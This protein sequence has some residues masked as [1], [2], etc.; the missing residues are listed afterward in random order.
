M[1]SDGV[2]WG[3]T[4][5]KF[6]TSNKVV[7]KTCYRFVTKSWRH[8]SNPISMEVLVFHDLFNP[9]YA[10]LDPVE[11]NTAHV[12]PS[13]LEEMGRGGRHRRCRPGPGQ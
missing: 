12:D 3:D 6:V 5:L 4:P 11:G 13:S 10:V 8:H 2:K 7:T 9:E 1:N